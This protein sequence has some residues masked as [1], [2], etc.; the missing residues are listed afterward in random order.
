MYR[1]FLIV[2]LYCLGLAR[3]LIVAKDTPP[4]ATPAPAFDGQLPRRSTT[5]IDALSFAEVLL[6]AIPQSLAQIAATDL[7][8]ASAILWSDFLDGKKPSWFTS[9]PDN[10]Q[11]YLTSEFGPKTTVAVSTTSAESSQSTSASASASASESASE[12]AVASTSASSTLP[13]LTQTSFI[14][15][16][17]SSDSNLATP[18]LTETS[19]STSGFSR[20][21]K[22]AV[23][24][25]IPL[26]AA[27][28][29]IIILVFCLIRQKRNSR[30]RRTLMESP[31]QSSDFLEPDMVPVA[32]TMRR[33]S[34]SNPFADP[35]DTR[36]A[37]VARQKRGSHGSSRTLTPVMEEARDD[38]THRHILPVPLPERSPR[39]SMDHP[40]ES[41]KDRQQP[42]ITT[43][44]LSPTQD[45]ASHD[46]HEQ[47]PALRTR[48]STSFSRPFGTYGRIGHQQGANDNYN[49]LTS[50]PRRKPVPQRAQGPMLESSRN[51]K[52][53][54]PGRTDMPWSA[55]YWKVPKRN[56]DMY[57]NV[58]MN[59]SR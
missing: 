2:L 22:L 34:S 35:P 41:W 46:W 54:V 43:T 40:P 18:T 33:A 6:T 57:E 19:D 10:V 7:S 49:A 25:G 1:I 17:A 5:P 52:T 11:D 8:A 13:A 31:L 48:E 58:T 51:Q 32:P 30:R 3:C 45:D 27:I 56:Y 12:S 16:T 47:H 23:A 38:D 20:A 26:A 44:S 55:S 14:T 36:T 42:V 4:L 29:A 15:V 28:L 39:R 21:D 24:L 50:L 37:A 9:L 53:V 59:E